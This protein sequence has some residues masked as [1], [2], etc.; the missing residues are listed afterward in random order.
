MNISVERA[1]GANKQES[2]WIEHKLHSR[3]GTGHGT[4]I[5]CCDIQVPLL[6]LA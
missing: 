3:R 4:C 5:D 6:K 2:A 1:V